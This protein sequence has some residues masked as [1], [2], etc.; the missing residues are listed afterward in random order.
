MVAHLH[1]VL[2]GTNNLVFASRRNLV[3]TVAD[4]LR[5]QSEQMR[6]PNE[7]FPHHGSLAKNL[8][9]DLEA[10]LKDGEL[11]TTA[12]ATTTLELGIDIGTVKSV[13]QIGPPASVAGQAKVADAI[14]QGHKQRRGDAREH[15]AN[16]TQEVK[17]ALEGAGM[18]QLI[19]TALRGSSRC[20]AR[21][22]QHCG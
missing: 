10:R 4:D 9:E 19:S 13:A 2:R 21:V 20:A 7:F 18:W 14:A 1:K 17:A 6:V 3:E 11:P 15:A 12:V 16:T 22:M 8:R 5:Q